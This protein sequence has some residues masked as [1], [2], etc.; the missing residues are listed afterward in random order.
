M[1]IVFDIDGTLANIEHR[2]HFIKEPEGW[3]GLPPGAWKPDWESFN[4]N[5][6]NDLPIS[7]MI[8]L[9]NTFLSD[10]DH[11]VIFATGRMETSRADTEEWL[12]THTQIRLKSSEGCYTG[13]HG[14][15]TGFEDVFNRPLLFMRKE[16][17]HR[18]D[19]KVK[20]EMLI[21]IQAHFHQRPDMVFDDRQQVVDMWREVGI[22]CCQVAKG[23]F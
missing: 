17:D 15:Y 3:Y 9:C 18:P 1:L 8:N 21:G 19:Y 2:L 14:H 11:S 13:S 10:E 6:K 16:G 7:E 12:S 22:R 4:S 20:R 5:V 23:D